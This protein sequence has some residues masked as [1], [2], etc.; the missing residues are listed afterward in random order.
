M[1]GANTTRK[2]DVPGGLGLKILRG[3]IRQ[4]GGRL[5]IASYNGFW[6]E[7]G[8]QIVRRTLASPYPGTV[9]T[10]EVDTDDDAAYVMREEI[11]P[12]KVF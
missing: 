7:S 11:D 3:F 2:G 8:K 4:N 6:S 9:I 5:V 10:I 1:T 12:S